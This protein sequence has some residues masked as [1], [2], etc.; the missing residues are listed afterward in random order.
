MDSLTQ[1]TLGAAVGELTLGKKVGNRAL[2]W[3]AVGGTIPDLDVLSAFFMSPVN[4][5]AFHRGISHSILFSILGAFFFGYIVDILYKSKYHQFLAFGGWM[6]VPIGV[7]FFM[8]RIFDQTAFSGTFLV[9][10]FGALA[11]WL[12]RKYFRS[13][14][15]P[16][17]A[18]RKE[19][20]WLF[21]WALF[22]HPL[23]DCFTTYGTQ[24][25]QPFSS[26]RVAFNA[27]SV[28]DPMYTV[29]FL[30]AMIS[31]SFFKR[32]SEYRRYLTLA[33]IGLSSA[34]L[35][36]TVFNK[37]RINKVW[38]ETLEDEGITYSRYMT[39]PTILNNALWY[40]LAETESGYVFGLYSV[41]DKEKSVEMI[42]VDRNDHLIP[43]GEDDR[44]I[45]ILKWFCND[46][47]TIS[48][49]SD[50]NIQFSDLRFGVFD[51]N[52]SEDT[53]IFNFTLLPPVENNYTMIRSDGG[54]PPGKE[55]EMMA[56]LWTRIK[57]I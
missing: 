6:L 56:S 17:D 38:T 10:I 32:N 28:A 37:Q 24:L 25:F 1:I 5:L 40:C 51:N 46:Y 53:Y 36:F 23:L 41:F 11:V 2:L 34:Y 54:P 20:T 45:Q 52:S 44:T 15:I 49:R 35:L 14:F 29:P 18:N 26:Y 39:S 21:F 31:V 50:G 19:W 3:G 42:R 13:P 27:I 22:T 7:L 16:P 48:K 57:G 4:D 55:K 47:Y 8:Y 30:L 12:F 33:G 43:G 9:I